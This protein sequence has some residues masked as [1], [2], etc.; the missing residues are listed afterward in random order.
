MTDRELLDKLRKVER[1]FA[2]AATEGERDAAADA[3]AR[4]RRRLAETEKAEPAIEY[5]FNLTDGWSKRLSQHLYG[6]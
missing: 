1:L 5:K 4:I 3:M 2:G 6:R